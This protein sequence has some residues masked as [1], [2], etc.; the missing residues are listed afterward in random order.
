[1]A[2]G[3]IGRY[4]SIPVKYLVDGEGPPNS[5]VTCHEPRAL[6]EGPSDEK[7]QAVF[8]IFGRYSSGNTENEE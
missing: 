6:V 1:M 8:G 7:L 5:F 3:C 2:A 4:P